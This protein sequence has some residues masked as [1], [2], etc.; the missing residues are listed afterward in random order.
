MLILKILTITL[1]N[2]E[3]VIYFSKKVNGINMK[4][5]YNTVKPSK[6]EGN[7]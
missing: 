1:S 3:I 2:Y 6:F 4:P 5:M 7:F